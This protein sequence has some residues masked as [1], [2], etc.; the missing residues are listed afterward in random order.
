[1]ECTKM[2]LLM[3]GPTDASLIT[4]GISQEAFSQGNK[5]LPTDEGHD[6]RETGELY[7]V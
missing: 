5:K 4:T 7:H 3:K 6:N 1:M 2:Y